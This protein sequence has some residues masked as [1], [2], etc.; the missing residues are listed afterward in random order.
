MHKAANVR[1]MPVSCPTC[2]QPMPV[3]PT[4]SRPHPV[5]DPNLELAVRIVADGPREGVTVR[6]GA[7]ALFAVDVPTPAQL[8]AARRLL[9]RAVVAGLLQC[10]DASMGLRPLTVFTVP[11]ATG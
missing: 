9:G 10:R 8:E 3:I 6:D 2:G 5:D 7:R 4:A 11:P 1:V